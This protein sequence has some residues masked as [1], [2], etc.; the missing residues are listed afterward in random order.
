MVQHKKSHRR[1]NTIRCKN[2]R[3]RKIKIARKVITGGDINNIL[4]YPGSYFEGKKL[5]KKKMSVE[6]EEIIMNNESKVKVNDNY[7]SHIGSFVIKS[8]DKDIKKGGASAKV[9]TS[10][11][12]RIYTIIDT[13]N[14]IVSGLATMLV[15]PNFQVPILERLDDEL[16]TV[17]ISALTLDPNISITQLINTYRDDNGINNIVISLHLFRLRGRRPILIPRSSHIT[18]HPANTTTQSWWQNPGPS[19]ITLDYPTRPR[20]VI[21]VRWKMCAKVDRCPP[22][23]NPPPFGNVLFS[24]EAED[25]IVYNQ[26]NHELGNFLGSCLRPVLDLMTDS[27]VFN[28]NVPPFNVLDF[29]TKQFLYD[30]LIDVCNDISS[31]TKKKV[32]PRKKINHGKRPRG[33]GGIQPME[34]DLIEV[35][36]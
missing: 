27:R 14:E 31:D 20:T 28:I 17:D 8:I 16:A 13:Y 22:D 34:W 35:N 6:I 12:A 5:D 21:G 18:F 10:R 29:Q 15:D 11:N 2:T 4:F 1:K 23:L 36:E 33:T 32:A 9:C 30:R 25:T 19:H 26:R 3:R 24:I 7:I